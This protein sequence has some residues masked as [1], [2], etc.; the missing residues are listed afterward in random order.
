MSYRAP[1]WLSRFNVCLLVSAQ[2]I[3]SQFMSLSPS[4][5]SVL[6]AWSLLGILSLSL[7]LCPSPT[8]T[9]SISLKINKLEEEEGGGGGREEEEKEKEKGGGG[10]GQPH[11]APSNSL[12]GP[13]SVQTAKQ[14]R[15]S[16]WLAPHSGTFIG[17]SP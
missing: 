2:V 11:Q 5:G 15:L 6:I 1:E 8:H 12:H 3:I 17:Q 9:V 10:A 4:S 16:Y 7:S 13:D 14:L